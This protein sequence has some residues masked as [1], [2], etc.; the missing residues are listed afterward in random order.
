MKP[1]EIVQASG[2]SKASASDI[3]PGEPTPHVST[4]GALWKQAG[5]FKATGVA[6]ATT[7]GTGVARAPRS[8][9]F[10]DQLVQPSVA[11]LVVTLA[12]PPVAVI[13]VSAGIEK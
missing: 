5:R 9:C 1:S 8:M 4:W 13:P 6:L 3:R 11:G 10:I 7:S 2:C 12:A